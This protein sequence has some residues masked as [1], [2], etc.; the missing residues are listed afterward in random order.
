[1]IDYLLKFPDRATADQYGLGAGYT[2]LD[3]EGFAITS[4]SGA[5]YAL[6]VIGEHWGPTGEMITTDDG[7]EYEE[8]IS[9]RC[10]WVLFRDLDDK[11]TPESV[12][13][14]IVWSSI[15]TIGSGENIKLVERP[16]DDPLIPNRFWA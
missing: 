9:D 7:I 14:Y 10:C 13:P 12:L 3:A 5:D 1:M 4:T 6:C 8:T 16:T 11:P 2:C 15:M